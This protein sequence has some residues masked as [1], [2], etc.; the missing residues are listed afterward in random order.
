ME[1]RRLLIRRLPRGEG[2]V[3]AIFAEE[4]RYVFEVDS[5]VLRGQWG[6]TSCGGILPGTHL[7]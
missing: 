7:L 6:L 4:H 2:M 3:Y 5:S 1:T